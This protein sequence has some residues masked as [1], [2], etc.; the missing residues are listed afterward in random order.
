MA[1]QYRIAVS[2]QGTCSKLQTVH[3][4]SVLLR[5]WHVLC[6]NRC[7]ARSS[8]GTTLARSS[9]LALAAKF[10]AIIRSPS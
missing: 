1:A 9:R 8:K 6:G 4:H 5:P 2:I 3:G 10:D 7:V